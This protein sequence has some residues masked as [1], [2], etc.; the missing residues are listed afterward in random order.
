MVKLTAEFVLQK[1]KVE[2]LK[3]IKKLD[4][5]SSELDEISLVKELPSIEICSLSLNKI[6]SLSYF[7]HCNNLQELFLRKN[8]ISD[9]FEVRSLIQCPKLRVLWLADN[10]IAQNP[11]YR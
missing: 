6:E 1:C 2:S 4:V 11:Y 5:W 7:S 9:L 10:P 8:L 3:K